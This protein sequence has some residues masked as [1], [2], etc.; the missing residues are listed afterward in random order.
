MHD[1]ESIREYCLSK[2]G[3]SES[4]P[5]DDVTLVFKVMNKVF[6]ILSLDTPAPSFNAKC[7]PD[8]ALEWR[9]KHYQIVPGF[10]M[11]KKHWN[12]VEVDQGLSESLIREIID[13]SYE[14]VVAGLS[15]KD[16]DALQ[17]FE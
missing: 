8:L 16:K 5:F 17:H 12:T 15:K 4:L 13:H 14:L 9:E 1:N 6:L 11:N 3:S 7:N 10:H 2:P